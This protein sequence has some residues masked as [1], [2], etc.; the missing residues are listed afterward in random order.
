V[1]TKSRLAG[2]TGIV[3]SVVIV[4]ASFA[5]MGPLPALASVT[6]SL[7]PADFPIP[8][9][10]STPKPLRAGPGYWAVGADG[11]VFA[12]GRAHFAGGAAGTPVR[13][14]VAG[15]AVTPSGRGY[16]L[17]AKDGGVFAYGDAPFRG[18]VATI[19]LNS[20]AVA[21]A[22][23]PTGDGYWIAGADGGVFAFGDAG[24][25]GGVAGHPLNQPIVSIA[26]TPSGRGYW[27]VAKDGGVFAF[28]DA[29]YFGGAAAM[30]LNRGVVAITSSQSGPGYWLAG[31]DGGVFAYGDAGFYGSAIG[32]PVAPIVGMATTP[33]GHG[34]W[35]A[36]S[37][38]GV[39]A[40][41][42]AGFY[43]APAEDAA[44][45]H[46]VGIA[47]G[48]GVDVRA[49]NRAVIGT[50]GWDVSWPQ[51]NA[52]LPDGGYAFAVV[53]VT[54]GKAFTANPCLGAEFHWA[55]HNGSVGSVYTNVNFPADAELPGLGDRFHRECPDVHDLNCQAY[56]YGYRASQDALHV[57]A[58]QHVSA[59]MWWMDV[60]TTNTWTK[61][62]PLNVVVVK[63]AFNGLH[64]AGVKVGIYSS[65][66]Q[67]NT[68]TGG[69]APGLPTWVAGPTDAGE[70]AA[71]CAP[72][73]SFGGGTPWM[74]QFPNGLDGNILCDAGARALLNSFRLPPAPAVPELPADFHSGGQ[75]P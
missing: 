41:G 69:Y 25:F 38:G 74:V 1:L 42:D 60:E 13:K 16:W 55:L 43:G 44:G 53:G 11:G 31:A 33:T 19:P 59:P 6:Q 47:A 32:V 51:C 67:W 15:M 21:I 39:F 71:A 46:I 23:T 64:D 63:G 58:A 56:W 28:G 62:Q 66:Y 10:E 5:G 4:L 14:P 7:V 75:S 45:S 22:S 36:G 12:Y 29:G 35:L 26:A 24:Y 34:Y 2:L 50:F 40:Y 65:A 61:N 73:Q 68:I 70:A 37:D 3:A 49:Q 48:V 8:P 52:R 27:L 18:G 30:A 57:A 54:G 17:V 20:S 9:L 72:S